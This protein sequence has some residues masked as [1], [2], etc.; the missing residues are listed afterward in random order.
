ME[1]SLKNSMELLKEVGIKVKNENGEYKKFND[2]IIDIK[3]KYDESSK[4]QRKEIENL[5]SGQSK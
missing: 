2:V 1:N 5:L 3:R 4:G